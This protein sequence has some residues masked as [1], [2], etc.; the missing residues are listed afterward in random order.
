MATQRYKISLNKIGLFPFLKRELEPSASR[1]FFA[2][3]V[4]VCAIL[5]SLFSYFLSVKYHVPFSWWIL[6]T[7]FSIPSIT[8]AATFYKSMQRMIATIVGCLLGFALSFFVKSHPNFILLVVAGNTFF[9]SVL[10]VRF[11]KQDYTFLLSGILCF[12]IFSASFLKEDPAQM[13]VFRVLDTMMGIVIYFFVSY[14]WPHSIGN[15]KH[16]QELNRIIHSKL[17]HLYVLRIKDYLHGTSTDSSAKHHL[18]I[19]IIDGILLLKKIE[20]EEHRSENLL[21]TPCENL[22]CLVNNISSSSRLNK[23]TAIFPDDFIHNMIEMSDIIA[24]LIKNMYDIK[25][26]PQKLMDRILKLKNLLSHDRVE[27][28]QNKRHLEYQ[29]RDNLKFYEFINVT[30][31]ILENF[32]IEQYMEAK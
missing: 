12:L 5:G 1:F 32:H 15:E 9:W 27:F 30:E 22:L 18:N 24:N 16:S 25:P 23:N 3:K 2:F 13:A 6:S 7:I 28:F 10:K 26:I 11:P 19:S 20:N 21:S 8:L 17:S 14:L 31:E 4:T 29:V